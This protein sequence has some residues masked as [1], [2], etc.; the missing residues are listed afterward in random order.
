MRSTSILYGIVVIVVVG[1]LLYSFS[2]SLVPALMNTPQKSAY[3]VKSKQALKKKPCA[4]CDKK[5][6][7]IN[8]MMHQWLNEKPEEV[9]SNKELSVTSAETERT[10]IVR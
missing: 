9:S 5:Q 6:K 10:D 4:C 1:M 3:T 8:Q 7:R 2:P